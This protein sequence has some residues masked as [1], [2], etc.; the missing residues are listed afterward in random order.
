MNPVTITIHHLGTCYGP[1]EGLEG[2]FRY[3]TG[4]IL[5]YDPSNG[6]YLDP[7]RDVYLNHDHALYAMG[8]TDTLPAERDLPFTPTT[9]ELL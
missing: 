1:R 4:A 7:A 2:P 8:V 6:H 3:R 5:Y 9:A